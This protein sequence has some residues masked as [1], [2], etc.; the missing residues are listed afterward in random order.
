[1]QVKGA[2][3]RACQALAANAEQQADMQ[4]PAARGSLQWLCAAGCRQLS[5]GWS[6]DPRTGCLA[7]AC[8]LLCLLLLVLLPVLHLCAHVR[9]EADVWLHL[10]VTAFC[11]SQLSRTTFLRYLWMAHRDPA[12]EPMWWLAQRGKQLWAQEYEALSQQCAPMRAP[13]SHMG[14]GR[15]P[16]HAVKGACGICC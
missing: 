4:T 3:Y 16:V 13:T 11:A 12:D 14:S 6:A 15:S 9:S 8:A 1:M 5:P 10:A 7:C 2:L